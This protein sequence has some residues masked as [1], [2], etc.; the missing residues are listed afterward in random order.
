M[1]LLFIAVAIGMFYMFINPRYE[2]ASRIKVEA[3]QYEEALAKTEELRVV[4]DE[5]LTQ[6]NSLSRS[7]IDRLNRIVPDSVD[8]VKMVADIDAVAGKYGIIIQ[9]VR[10][11]EEV[12][13]DSQG[14][15]DQTQSKPYLTTTVA[16]RFVGTYENLLPFLR[17]LERSL[18][19]VDVKAAS[20]SSGRAQNNIY[21][22]DISIQ[23]HWLK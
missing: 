12:V 23:T 3:D 15:V 17:D 5:L 4:R 19:V 7:D 10:I 22:F 14:I 9:D 8:V 6:Y 18:Q 16:F 11:A 2:N 20:F 21:S 13:D 1:P